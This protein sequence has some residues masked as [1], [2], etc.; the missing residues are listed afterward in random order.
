[1]QKSLGTP[2]P[3]GLRAIGKS[4]RPNYVS[5]TFQRCVQDI[6]ITRTGKPIIRVQGGRWDFSVEFLSRII[7]KI[8][9]YSC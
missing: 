2:I 6:S 7:L 9:E 3:S 5:H 4:S 8:I 1:M